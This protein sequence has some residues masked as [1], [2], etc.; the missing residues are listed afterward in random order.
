MQLVNILL[1]PLP[2]EDDAFS[3]GRPARMVRHARLHQSAHAGLHGP[4]V[5]RGQADAAD[6]VAWRKN[7]GT[8]VGYDTWRMHFGEPGGSGSV[9]SANATVPEPTTLVM[10]MLATVAI[11][12][13]GRH[14]DPRVPSTR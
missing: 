9:V 13:R 6:Y 10:L 2:L 12:L 14:S 4:L 11:R 1:R 7:D 3:V 8:Q 5:E